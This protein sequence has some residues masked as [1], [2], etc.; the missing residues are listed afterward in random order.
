MHVVIISDFFFLAK[1]HNLVTKRRPLQQI[2][3]ICWGKKCLI[4][5]TLWWK[6]WPIVITLWGEKIEV[7]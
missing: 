5:V 6:K 7:A 2:Q 4:V 3:R 1:F